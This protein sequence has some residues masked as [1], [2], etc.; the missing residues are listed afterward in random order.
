MNFRKK[1]TLRNKNFDRQPKVPLRKG[2][3]MQLKSES[4]QVENGNIFAK[5]VVIFRDKTHIDYGVSTKELAV[6]LG[7]TE[8][9]VRA[10]LV[11]FRDWVINR[12]LIVYSMRNSLG[13]RLYYNIY[14]T[15]QWEEV[16]ARNTRNAQGFFDN[17]KKFDEII[18]L[19][20]RQRNALTEEAY[21]HAITLQIENSVGQNRRLPYRKKRN[22]NNKS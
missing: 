5:L 4:E 21:K 6:A 18:K 14:G 9:Q 19:S 7:L 17:I 15:K 8:S 13:Q 11:R 3:V 1:N 12:S 20:K 10:W 2:I 16:K 22:N